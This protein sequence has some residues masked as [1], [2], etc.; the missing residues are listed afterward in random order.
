MRN[1]QD[2]F[3][4]TYPFGLFLMAYSDLRSNFEL[5]RVETCKKTKET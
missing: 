1:F 3:L 2:Y 4:W 5:N